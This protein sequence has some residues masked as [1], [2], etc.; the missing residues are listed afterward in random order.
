MVGFI[1]VAESGTF[2][3]HRAQC[4][5]GKQTKKFDI[6]TSKEF[7]GPDGIKWAQ[8]VQKKKEKAPAK[9]LKLP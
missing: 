8:I 1:Q 3:K 6:E 7:V 9:E 4:F 2:A 5:F